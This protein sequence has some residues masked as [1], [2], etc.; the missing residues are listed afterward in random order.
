MIGQNKVHIHIGFL[1]QLAWH[2]FHDAKQKTDYAKQLHSS[3][4]SRSKDNRL[5]QNCNCSL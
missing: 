4:N 3:K 2:C 1:I 5:T